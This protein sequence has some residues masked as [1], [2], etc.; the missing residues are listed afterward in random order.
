MYI[1]LF[2][3]LVPVIGIL[4]T[5]IVTWVIFE[6]VRATP[7]FT[8]DSSRPA[9]L[10][11]LQSLNRY[12]T[13]SFTIEKIIDAGTSGNE[14][15]QLLFGD[16]ILLIAHGEVIA[17]FDLQKVQ[18]EDIIIQNTAITIRLPAPEILSATLDNEK[19]K[20][21]DRKQGLLTHGNKDL[22][23]ATRI[24]AQESI[25]KAACDGG[26][27]DEASKNAKKQM[28]SILTSFNFTTVTIAV[29]A[30]TCK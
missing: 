15:Q 22:E 6:K 12:E 17:G 23:T 1:K 10:K 13:A 30:A 25:R 27:L 21:Y 4:A 28:T 20:V 3:L 26:I 18:A 7:A 24:A 8:I 14:F 9:I 16:K 29:P 2:K 19:T 11:Q 5:V